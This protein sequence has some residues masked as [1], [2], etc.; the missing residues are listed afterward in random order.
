MSESDT[1]FALFE[2][3][4]QNRTDIVLTIVKDHPELIDAVNEDFDTVL[5]I[6]C[7]NNHT[8]MIRALLSC[9]SSI[10]IQNA[11]GKTPVEVNDSQQVKDVIM[12]S[13]FLF[14]AQSNVERVKDLIECGVSF[15]RRNILLYQ[16]WG[17]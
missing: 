10:K 6:A 5:H 1:R 3:A 15:R 11:Q 8:D 16:F 14:A 2:A 7:K 13:L 12:Q 4:L 9:G 17:K